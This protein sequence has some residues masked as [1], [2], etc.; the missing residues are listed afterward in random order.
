[1]SQTTNNS[2]AAIIEQSITHSEAVRH[3]ESK[4]TFGGCKSLSV[5]DYFRY[6]NLLKAV[7]ASDLYLCLECSA[8]ESTG[9]CDYD[10]ECDRCQGSGHLHKTERIL[11][12]MNLP[13]LQSLFAAILDQNHQIILDWLKQNPDYKI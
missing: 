3:C 5:R 10:R 2:F 1:M 12:T 13:Q 8:C 7:Y 6:L 9:Y 11:K 4:L